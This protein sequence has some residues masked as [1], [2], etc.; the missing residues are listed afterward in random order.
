[1]KFKKALLLTGTLVTAASPAVALVSC[2]PEVPPLNPEWSK[3]NDE[4]WNGDGKDNLGILGTKQV[5]RLQDLPLAAEDIF[6]WTVNSMQKGILKDVVRLQDFAANLGTNKDWSAVWTSILDNIIDTSV[7]GINGAAQSLHQDSQTEFSNVNPFWNKI[8][9][10][11]EI[12]KDSNILNQTYNEI[13]ELVKNNPNDKLGVLTI[14]N[15][16][17]EVADATATKKEYTKGEYN[18]VVF[19]IKK[20]VNPQIANA[21]KLFMDKTKMSPDKKALEMFGG[22]YLTGSGFGTVRL[23]ADPTSS[24]TIFPYHATLAPGNSP[25]YKD[26]AAKSTIK[27]WFAFGPTISNPDADQADWKMNITDADMQSV[28]DLQFVVYYVKDWKTQME[29][30][31]VSP[32]SGTL[33]TNKNEF[34]IDEIDTF[35]VPVPEL[36]QIV[37][38]KDYL[39]M[40]DTELRAVTTSIVDDLSFTKVRDQI[41][42]PFDKSYKEL[43]AGLA[44]SALPVIASLYDIHQFMN[45]SRKL[46]SSPDPH[47]EPFRRFLRELP[48]IDP[49]FNLAMFMQIIEWQKGIDI[50][51]FTSYGGKRYQILDILPRFYRDFRIFVNRHSDLYDI[52]MD[53][54]SPTPKEVK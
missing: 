36:H 4:K 52:M 43:V 31:V 50:E 3:E 44:P 49:D 53:K 21:K 17:D 30:L 5:A 38:P 24:L 42:D 54:T 45:Q 32:I 34:N 33:D 23:N 20:S 22:T 35:Y 19:K 9:T 8:I 13:E 37:P 1:M 26:R 2:G 15:K 6:E 47:Q 14:L 40:S 39:K 46:I 7:K 48:T 16:R 51:P 12:I 27:D 18:I 41:I 25:A 11:A 28:K 29:N 10:K